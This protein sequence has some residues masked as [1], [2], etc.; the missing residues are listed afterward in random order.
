MFGLLLTNG[1]HCVDTFIIFL[2]SFSSFSSFRKWH[3]GWKYH[4][5]AGNLLAVT[6]L[7]AFQDAIE[8]VSKLDPSTE[9][10][11]EAKLDRLT[12]QLGVL[13]SEEESEY[14]GMLQSTIPEALDSIFQAMWPIDSPRWN[15]T[16]GYLPLLRDPI[17]CHTGIL[18][19]E[20]RFRGILTE[21]NI[22]GNVH[23][24]NYDMANSFETLEQQERPK[25]E[26]GTGFVDPRQPNSI[27]FVMSEKERE[28][29]PDTGQLM[30][31]DFGDWYHLS[32]LQGW[33]S[34]VLPNDSEI[35][36]YNFNPRNGH[37]WIF[38]CLKKCSWG[39]CPKDDLHDYLPGNWARGKKGKSPPTM[40]ERVI[41]GQVEIEINQ[42]AGTY[43]SLF[44]LPGQDFFVIVSMIGL[45]FAVV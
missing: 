2:L 11:L 36:Y 19:A 15:A 38:L 4:A 12:S 28:Q 40:E 10:T 17:L 33:R 8:E 44:L 16:Q 23:N 3:Q 25:K 35:Q 43:A 9:E 29:C 31:H 37:K 1:M 22:T 41:Y 5:L 7:D 30:R 34:I 32:S 26:V 6:L 20:I 21:S 39:K 27:P 24:Q 14:Q 45:R 42:I 18:P 13:N